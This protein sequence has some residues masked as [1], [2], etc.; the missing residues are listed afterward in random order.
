M[1]RILI[2]ENVKSRVY[3]DCGI[4]LVN[5]VWRVGRSNNNKIFYKDIENEKGKYVIDIL[6]DVSGF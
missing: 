4:I 5:R 6:L 1:L 3:F 2:E